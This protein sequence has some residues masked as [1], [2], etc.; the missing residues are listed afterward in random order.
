MS[1]VVRNTDR[2]M[3]AACGEGRKTPDVWMLHVTSFAT[4]SQYTRNMYS[5]DFKSNG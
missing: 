2:N 5:V 3:V 1:N 4:R